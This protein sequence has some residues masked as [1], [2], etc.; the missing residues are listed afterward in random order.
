VDRDYATFVSRYSTNSGVVTANRHINFLRRQVAPIAS[1]T[2][3]RFFTPSKP[4][5]RNPSR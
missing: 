5:R 4:T 1:P 2:T 3:P